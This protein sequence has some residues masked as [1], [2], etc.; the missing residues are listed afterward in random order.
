MAMACLRLVTLFPLRPLFSVPRFS[1]CIA[2][3]TF[4]PAI[5]LYFLPEDFFFVGIEPSPFCFMGSN[6][7]ERGCA[8]RPEERRQ[9]KSANSHFGRQ[10][11]LYVHPLRRIL[12]GVTGDAKAIALAAVAR[13]S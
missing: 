13:I 7:E 12:A 9:S 11:V 8:E 4:L 1:S 6:G 2:R 10:N 5:G 3:S